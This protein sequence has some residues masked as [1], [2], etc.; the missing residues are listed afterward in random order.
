MSAPK[1]RAGTPARPLL[2]LSA[3]DG[4]VFL[5]ATVAALAPLLHLEGP[6][7]LAMGWTVSVL[8]VAAVS[9]FLGGYFLRPKAPSQTRALVAA[10]TNAVLI[11]IV[12]VYFATALQIFGPVGPALVVL[13]APALVAA[14]MVRSTPPA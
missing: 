14:W 11:V 7:P 9:G 10:I 6:F 8:A 13:A 12:A 3:A 5:L 4:V 2:Y 1:G